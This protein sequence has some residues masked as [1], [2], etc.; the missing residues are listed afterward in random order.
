ML[1]PSRFWKDGTRCFGSNSVHN[2]TLHFEDWVR[3]VESICRNP[4]PDR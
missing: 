1:V 3:E 2:Q 4:A